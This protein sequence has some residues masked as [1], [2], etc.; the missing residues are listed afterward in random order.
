VLTEV[1]LEEW[2]FIAA[3]IEP[4]CTDLP[5][6]RADLE[7]HHSQAWR[8]GKNCG[9]SGYVVTHTG[10]VRGSGVNAMWIAYAAGR[11]FRGR[12]V[13]RE[14]ADEVAGIA[15]GWGLTR[16]RIEGRVSA[17]GRVLPGFEEIEP[18]VLERVL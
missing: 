15:R 17:W 9:A 7:R 13:M 4:A 14:V 1:G 3:T 2:P 5:D 10:A 12:A 11:C 6:L 8:L 18:G 16:L